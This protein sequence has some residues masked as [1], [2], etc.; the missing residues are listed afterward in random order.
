[1]GTTTV[2]TDSEDFDSQYDEYEINQKIRNEILSREILNFGIKKED[3]ILH[4]GSG[5]RNS[6]LFDYMF[7]LKSKSLVNDLKIKYTSVDVNSDKNKIIFDKNNEL[8]EP[9]DIVLYNGSAQDYLDNNTSEYDWVIITGLFDEILYGDK[10]F[11]F[12]DKV[13]SESLKNCKE[14]LILSFDLEKENNKQYIEDIIFMIGDSS[15]KHKI[16]RLN[17][18]DY[19]ICIYKYYHSIIQQ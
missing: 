2:Q 7:Q 8:E 16:S 17:E 1:M 11:D 6:V 9:I 13:L 15:P 14:G 19:L 10:Q 3:S 4:L 18:F 12:I 5:F